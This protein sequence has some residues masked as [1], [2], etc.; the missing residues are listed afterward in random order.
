M[1]NKKKLRKPPGTATTTITSVHR[2]GTRG[3]WAEG[4]SADVVFTIRLSGPVPL[5]AHCRDCTSI[6]TGL[7]FQPGGSYEMVGVTHA[8]G[9]PWLT[10]RA[11]Q[12]PVAGPVRVRCVGLAGALTGP[13][14]R[15]DAPAGQYLVSYDPEGND[16]LGDS[17]W[18]PDPARAMTFENSAAAVEFYRSVPAPSAAPGRPAQPAADRAEHRDRAGA[19]VTELGVVYAT[20]PTCGHQ[21]GTQRASGLKIRCSRC[22]QDRGKNVLVTVPERDGNPARPEP[23][24][25]GKRIRGAL[26]AR[27]AE[28]RIPR[29]VSRALRVA[30]GVYETTCNDCGLPAWRVRLSPEAQ[31]R[32]G[33]RSAAV[34]LEP[35]RADGE[36][37]GVVV[38]GDGLA[39]FS[40]KY[41][42]QYAKHNCPARVVQC[43]RCGAAIRVLNQPPGSPSRL[44]VLD[45]DED[46]DSVVAVDEH[47]Y[48]VRDPD[49]R[50]EGPR[51]RWHALHVPPADRRGADVDVSRLMTTKP[52]GSDR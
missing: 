26:G 49:R 23:P 11:R 40:G 1:S 34:L 4:S 18:S 47:G 39:A 15:Q 6:V 30:R 51:Y 14:G 8:P 45:A 42:G 16:G 19:V 9:C 41:P 44:A 36:P 29:P 31:A 38:G 48:A 27:S 13:T 35:R 33:Y 24:P 28:E 2:F 50:I 52:S 20:C 10:A 5:D 3:Q 37:G 46:P 32:A 7:R 21:T 22:Y 12:S 43:K 25:L 17:E